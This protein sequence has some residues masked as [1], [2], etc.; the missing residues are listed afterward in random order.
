M[1]R[2][3]TT[4]VGVTDFRRAIAFWTQALDYVPKREIRED[5]DLMIL[6]P[7]NGGSGAHVALDVS[8]SPCRS[9]REC[10]STCSP[11]RPPTSWPRS[12]G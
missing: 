10:T 3:G 7:R 11:A 8:V 12:S 4:V 2:I 1:L 9:T 5:D 6:V